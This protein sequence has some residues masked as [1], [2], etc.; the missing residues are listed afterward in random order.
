MKLSIVVP[1]YNEEKGVGPFLTKLK[2]VI[3]KNNIDCEIIIVDDGSK[4]QTPEEVKKHDVTLIQHP[5]NKGYGAA[6]KTGARKSSGDY[7]L[8]IDGDGQHDPQDIMNFIPGF[9][10]YD[11]IVGERIYDATEPFSRKFS[12]KIITSVAN[13]MSD[14]KIADL[15]SGFRAIRRELLLDYIDLLP[16]S[17]SFTTTITI[18]CIKSGFDVTYVPVRIKAREGKSKINP[19]DF[20]RFIILIIRTI[21]FFTPLKVF[22]PTSLILGLLGL[23]SMSYTLTLYTNIDDSAVFLL[24]ASMLLFFF[25]FLA[26]QISYLRRSRR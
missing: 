21:M 15:N 22:L 12:K 17:F 4:D 3:R 11:M 20:F 19:F 5:Y 25:G 9:G 23:A 16:N 8:F 26:D 10:K 13:Y 7:V 18:I 24:T 2:D 1:V 6:L 14:A